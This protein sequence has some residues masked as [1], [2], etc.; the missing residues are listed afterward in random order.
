MQLTSLVFPKVVGIFQRELVRVHLSVKTIKWIQGD[1]YATG[2]GINGTPRCDG[3]DLVNTR[4]YI[5]EMPLS[6]RLD[7]FALVESKEL[8]I[9]IH[10]KARMAS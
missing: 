1:R 8:E 5:L 7:G 6:K 3:L 4:L 10:I 9:S 2:T